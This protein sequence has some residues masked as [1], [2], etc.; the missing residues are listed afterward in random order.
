MTDPKSSVAVAV[1]DVGKMYRMYAKPQDRLK[2]MLFW[3]LGGRYGTDFWALRHV[4]FEVKRGERFGVV[5]R[6]GSGKSTVLQLI[7]GTLAPTEG[8]VEI[9]G[10]V[11]ALLELG[12]G[13]NPEFTGRENVFIN[14]AIHG[15]SREQISE[16]F[17][18]IAAFA[19]IGEFL[20]QPVKLYSSGMFVRL[21]F[22]VGTS[23]DADVLLIDE[24]LAVGDVFFRQKCYR[25]L[26]TLRDRGVSIVLVSHGMGDIEEFCDRALLLDHGRAL[27]VGAPAE[28]VQ[29]YYLVEQATRPSAPV[30]ASTGADLARSTGFGEKSGPPLDPVP[31]QAQV[32]DGSARCLG[33]LLT[34]EQLRPCHAF[35][36]G[37][38]AVFWAEFE[39]SRET[40][41]L[42][43]GVV[44]Q[45]DKGTIIHGKSTLEADSVVPV[46][47][48]RG[49]RVQVRQDIVLEVAAGEYTFE[50]GLGM[51]NR[52]IYARRHQALYQEL[53]GSIVRLCVVPVA[54]QFVVTFRRPTGRIQLTHH[55]VANLPGEIR[56]TAQVE[57]DVGRGPR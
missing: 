44:I 50:M 27:F 25:R 2:Q 18:A 6:N 29:R 26:E 7:A 39:V 8:A 37:A 38:R 30:D 54:G 23:I 4:S 46:G 33:V 13:F 22:A 21:A 20:D 48:P 1:R 3:R 5:G 24:A 11:S 19:D 28:T 55:G 56:V 43:A 16:R 53:A 51:V 14:A 47:L 34:D 12:S 45:N 57:G 32:T 41:V 10:R 36:Q 40:D 31:D 35:E 42:L 52:E 17:D 49:A 9:E 15:L